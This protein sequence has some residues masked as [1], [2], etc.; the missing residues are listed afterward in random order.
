M[1]LREFGRLMR[2]AM[3]FCAVSLSFIS[4]GAANAQ[5]HVLTVVANLQPLQT[6]LAMAGANSV[7]VA[8][9]YDQNGNR[10]SQTVTPVTTTATN[11]GEAAYGCFV[12]KQ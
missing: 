3:I 11:W 2:K 8:M 5:A 4:P 7:C 6:W 1:C 9:T 12:W 10:L